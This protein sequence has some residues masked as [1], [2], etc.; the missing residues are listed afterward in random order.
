MGFRNKKFKVIK[1]RYRNEV[2]GMN[3][4]YIRCEMLTNI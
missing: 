1:K 2:N 3:N 4:K